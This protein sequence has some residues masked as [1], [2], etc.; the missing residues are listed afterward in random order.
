MFDILDGL[1]LDDARLFIRILFEL[2]KAWN[3]RLPKRPDD[4][5]P[6]SG[7]RPNRKKGQRKS[8][9]RRS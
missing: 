3:A 4:R 1:T 9:A 5:P 2:L 6:M 7:P 8:K